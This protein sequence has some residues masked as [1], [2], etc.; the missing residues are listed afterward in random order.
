MISEERQVA[1]RIMASTNET[2]LL[3]RISRQT[4]NTLPVGKPLC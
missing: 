2:A 3:V 1:R 4:E